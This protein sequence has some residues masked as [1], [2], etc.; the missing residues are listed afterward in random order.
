M[1]KFIAVAAIAAGLLSTGAAAQAPSAREAGDWITRIGVSG[2]YP[3]S[4]NLDL[5]GLGMLEVDDSYMLTFNVAYLLTPNWG[6]ELLAA[7]PFEHDITLGGSRVGSAK[8]LPPTLS[9]QYY[10]APDSQWQPYIGAG[11]N[12]TLFF[13]E[14]TRGALDGTELQLDSSVGFAAQ[15]GLDYRLSESMFINLDLRYIDLETDANVDALGDLGT[16]VIDPYVASINIGW[17]F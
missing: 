1:M 15:I 6:I 10:F 12:L 4:N 5:G 11:M 9:V 17:E 7:L 8:Q 14:S 3:K 16:V 2:I 13:D